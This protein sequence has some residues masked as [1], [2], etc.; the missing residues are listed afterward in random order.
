MK[1]QNIVEGKFLSRPN[2][3][4]AYV[5]ILG[6]EEIC[7]VKNTGRCR[8]LLLPG[9]TVFLEEATNPQRKTK[10][11]LI[12][13]QKGERLINMDSQ[14][15]NRAFLEWAPKY[16]GENAQIYPEKAYKNSRFDFYAETADGNRHFV[17][18]KGVTLEQDGIVMFPDAPTERGRKHI[19][20]LCDCVE[21]GYIAHLFFVV[22]MKGVRYFTPNVKTDPD[23]AQALRIA[24]QKGVNIIAVDSIITPDSM[25]ISEVLQVR[26]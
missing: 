26:L 22:Q 11:D 23:F 20:E 5:E 13:V 19:L 24:R 3:F 25:T 15:P 1:Y 4:I 18:V 7:H 12:A 14:A 21:H 9:A 6:K 17:E 16:F 10:Y 2:R 8:E